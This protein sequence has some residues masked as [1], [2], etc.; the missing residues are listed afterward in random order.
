MDSVTILGII[1]LTLM[2][3]LGITRHF[4]VSRENHRAHEKAQRLR[5]I[6]AVRK[7]EREGRIINY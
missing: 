4:V 7:A 6:E 1:T 3:P 5:N 2:L